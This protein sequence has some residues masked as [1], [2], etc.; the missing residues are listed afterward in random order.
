MLR[1]CNFFDSISFSEMEHSSLTPICRH[2]QWSLFRVFG[3]HY[4]IFKG[5]SNNP[6]LMPEG[7]G[8][9][10]F[11]PCW[12]QNEKGCLPSLPV[13]A[14]RKRAA[15]LHSLLM[16]E[17]KGLPL[18]TPCW[19]Q[20]EKGCLSS[21]P[22]DA[23]RNL[24][25]QDEARWRKLSGAITDWAATKYCEAKFISR[26]SQ[27]GLAGARVGYSRCPKFNNSGLD[28]SLGSSITVANDR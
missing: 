12:C 22:V 6:V 8:L 26:A 28:G 10:L 9:P 16:P 21:L 11:T 3:C 4:L 15:S 17:G 14:T 20:K 19:Y 25:K 13:D 27:C 1:N 5:T 7:K 24:G 18:F 2:L 23:R